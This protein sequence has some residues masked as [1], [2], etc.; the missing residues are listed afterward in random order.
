MNGVKINC[1]EMNLVNVNCA[2]MNRVNMNSAKM[3]NAKMSF[4]QNEK[5]SKYLALKWTASRLMYHNRQSQ[6]VQAQMHAFHRVLWLQQWNREVEAC[7][8]A[9]VRQIAYF[10]WLPLLVS[11]LEGY[12]DLLQDQ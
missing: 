1:A 7:K 9:A 6:N 2:K 10:C 3:N 5:A 4:R 8:F 11:G 12:F